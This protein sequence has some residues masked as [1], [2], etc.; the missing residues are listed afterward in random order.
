MYKIGLKLTFHDHYDNSVATG[1]LKYAKKKIDWEM[2]GQGYGFFNTTTELDALIARIETEEEK[3]EYEKLGIPVVDIAGAIPSKHFSTVRNDDW[4][5]GVKCGEYL[6]NL[7]AKDYA[8]VMVKDVAWARERMLGFCSAINRKSDELKTFSE[9][10]SWWK[11]L[12]STS[13]NNLAHWLLSLKK[14]TALFCCND[15]AAMKVSVV[16]RKLQIKIPE[17]LMILGVDNEELLCMLAKPTLSSLSLQLEKIGY[18]AAQ[19]LDKILSGNE[20]IIKIVYRIPSMSVIE[21]DSTSIISDDDSIVAKAVS[22]IKMNTESICS[23]NDIVDQL[24]CC[25]RSLEIKF[26]KNM[27]TTVHAYLLN[28]KLNKAHRL[29]LSSKDS[30]K[31]ICSEC[32][33]HSLQ[34]FHAAFLKKYQASPAEYRKHNN[35]RIGED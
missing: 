8:M 35:I 21:R 32:G 6:A 13:T 11:D 4:N 22:F 16:C 17:E 30:V 9:P 12:Y 5:T 29:L 31:V 14:G 33:F 18:T 15:L 1:V 24:P 23:V 34:R 19:V 27:H 28:E 2:N 20:D 26:K 3:E 25:R 10:L 7:G